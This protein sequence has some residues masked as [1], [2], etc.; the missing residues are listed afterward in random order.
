MY[1]CDLILLPICA[2]STYLYDD[3]ELFK[4]LFLIVVY[5][6]YYISFRGT[7]QRFNIYAL[8]TVITTISLVTICHRT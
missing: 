4:N 1:C 7:T 5:T 8:Y 3:V 2:S 6:Q